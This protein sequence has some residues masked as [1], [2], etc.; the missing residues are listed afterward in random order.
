MA[1]IKGGRKLI[2]EDLWL[3]LLNGKVI[4]AKVVEPIF[5]DPNGVRK[6]GI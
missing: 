5:F 4:K 3:P 6:D 2:G 1:L